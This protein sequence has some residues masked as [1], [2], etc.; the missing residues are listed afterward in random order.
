M[1]LCSGLVP[2][3]ALP[4]RLLPAVLSTDLTEPRAC[5]CFSYGHVPLRGKGHAKDSSVRKQDINIMLSRFAGTRRPV[6]GCIQWLLWP[7]GSLVYQRIIIS[8]WSQSWK[9]IWGVG[10]SES[11]CPPLKILETTRNCFSL[12]LTI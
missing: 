12:A 4:V 9:P 6:F 11:Q 3:S 7:R 8:S 2:L 10:E 1:T 5:I